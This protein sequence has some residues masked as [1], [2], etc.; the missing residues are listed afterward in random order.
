MSYLLH[1]EKRGNGKPVIFLHGFLESLRMWEN[2]KVPS[3]FQAVY[4]DLPGHGKSIKPKMLCESIEEMAKLISDV[5]DKLTLDSYSVIGHSMGGYVSLALK[6]IDSRCTNVMLLN[7]NFWSDSESK[8]KDRMRIAEIVQT[9]QSRF[10][11]EAIPNL[12]IDPSAYDKEVK[13]LIRDAMMMSPTAIAK[14]SIA[15]SR[16]VD[17]KYIIEKNQGIFTI[18]QGEQDPV[19]DVI[20]MRDQAENLVVNFI[21]MKNVGH[22]AHIESPQVI[23][24][25]I[26]EFLVPIVVENPN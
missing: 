13:G 22:M 12:F 18:I 8:K 7:S 6:K 24:K 20:R 2:V 4:I 16:R 5:A 17:Q 25:Y 21:E 14:S 3:N 19:V 23:N 11:Y 10:I 9:K 26:R 1:F 15:M